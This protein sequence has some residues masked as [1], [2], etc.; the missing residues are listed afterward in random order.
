[1]PDSLPSPAPPSLALRLPVLDPAVLRDSHPL[2]Q[3]AAQRLRDDG[4]Y[5]PG[6]LMQE[7]SLGQCLELGMLCARAL[8]AKDPA[9]L[10]PVLHFGFILAFAEG[11]FVGAD[12]G[13]ETLQ[14]V[15]SLVCVRLQELQEDVEPGWTRQSMEHPL[16][17]DQLM[18]LHRYV[19]PGLGPR[20]NH[21]PDIDHGDLD[22]H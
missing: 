5:A 4:M 18:P 11:Y 19:S 1:M 9:S 13:A 8:L 10:E 7:L 6:S 15:M 21:G 22:P 14:G 17:W 20:H 12:S 2:V 3:L 16:R